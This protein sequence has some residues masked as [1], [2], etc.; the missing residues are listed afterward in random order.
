MGWGRRPP[1]IDRE[2]IKRCPKE[3]E[4]GGKELVRVQEGLG[5]ASSDSQDGP[6]ADVMGKPDGFL[7]VLGGGS[8]VSN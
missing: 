1:A 3:G 2:R 5:F 7:K 6:S 4:E 8:L